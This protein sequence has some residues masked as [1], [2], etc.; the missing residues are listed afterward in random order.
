MQARQRTTSARG[1]GPSS[2]TIRMYNVGFGDCFLMSFHYASGDRHVLIDYGSTSAPKIGSANYM[3][4]VAKDIERPVTES[5]ISLLPRIATRTISA[6]SRQR[7]APP[8]R[9]SLR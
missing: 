8:E 2:V 4:D 9:L 6:A 5:W 3:T 1:K 7:A